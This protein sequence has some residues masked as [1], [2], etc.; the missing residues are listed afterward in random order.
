VPRN[1][2][3]PNPTL[4]LAKQPHGLVRPRLDA[5]KTVGK[6]LLEVY[7]LLLVFFGWLG[8]GAFGLAPSS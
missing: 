4:I 6:A 8:R 2:H 1:G 7:L 3:Q 5:R